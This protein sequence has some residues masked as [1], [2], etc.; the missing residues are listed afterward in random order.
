MEGVEGV[1]SKYIDW[2]VIH[3][4]FCYISWPER[5]CMELHGVALAGS[6]GGSIVSHSQRGTG[7]ILV[8]LG[9]VPICI[10]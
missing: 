8:A 1:Y 9:R 3:L 10:Y 4:P 7:S 6:G 2:E 5:R